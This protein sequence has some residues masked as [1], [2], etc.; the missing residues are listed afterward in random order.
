MPIPRIIVA[1]L[2]V[3]LWSGLSVAAA[4]D[5]RARPNI[6]F[7]MSDDHCA[8]AISAYG[9]KVNVTPNIDRLATEGMRF[10]NCFVTNGICAPSRA[11]ILT[12]LHSHL[13][14]KTTNGRPDFDGG[15]LTFPKVLQ[16]AGYQTA[17]IGKWHLRSTPTG[18]DHF[19]VLI[20]Q[21]PYYNPPTRRKNDSER[22][23]ERVE[24]GWIHDGH[25]HRPRRRLAR[26][27]T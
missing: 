6:I 27:W 25:H 2:L 10:D 21:G 9:S 15:Q 26:E 16:G 23:F 18:F 24:R 22:G 1:S 13:N 8:Q 4:A 14:G 11:V 20:G 5:E 12:G 7:I 3:V 17:M 19:D